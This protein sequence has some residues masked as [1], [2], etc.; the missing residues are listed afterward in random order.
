MLLTDRRSPRTD[1]LQSPDVGC[2][3]ARGRRTLSH[4]Q[5][6]RSRS[7]S[8]TGCGGQSAEEVRV[9][10]NEKFDATPAVLHRSESSNDGNDESEGLASTTITTMEEEQPRTSPLSDAPTAILECIK[11]T[12][13]YSINGQSR[14]AILLFDSGSTTSSISP[15]LVEELNLLRLDPRM[16]RANVFGSTVPMLYEGA[17]VS[18]DLLTRE[19]KSLRIQVTTSPRGLPPFQMAPIFED[20]LAALRR[21]AIPVP[22]TREAPDILI[23]QDLFDLFE[24]TTLPRLPQGFAVTSTILGPTISGA[25]RPKPTSTNAAASTEGFSPLLNLRNSAKDSRSPSPLLDLRDVSTSSE[26]LSPLLDLQK[27]PTTCRCLSQ[28]WMSQIHQNGKQRRT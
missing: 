21:D 10:P 19:N 2:T 11:T 9:Q 17:T 12:I 6:R 14:Q 7:S 16:L 3:Q 20:Q 26:G 28:C 23:G 1:V 22:V 15:Q 27:L 5:E 18:F 8:Y 24:R 25:G 4:T 13:I